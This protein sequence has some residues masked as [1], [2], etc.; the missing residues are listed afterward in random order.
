MT[1]SKI[2]ESATFMIHDRMGYKD[3]PDLFP[4]RLHY[5]KAWTLQSKKS[6]WVLLQSYF[7]IVAAYDKNTEILYVFDYYSHTTCTHI[8]R[9]RNWLK[10]E[11]CPTTV[12]RVNLYNDSKTPKYMGRIREADDF[13]SVIQQALEK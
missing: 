11:F 13:A 8:S 9:F 1:R 10:N 5:C 2:I 3:F 4:K 7:K 12:K 6:K